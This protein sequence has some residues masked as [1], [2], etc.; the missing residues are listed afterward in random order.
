MNQLWI[1]IQKEFL[2]TIRNRWL[3]GFVIAYL[4]LSASI[5]FTAHWQSQA[6]DMAT[7]HRIDISLMNLSLFLV[8]L[9][10][11]IVSSQNIVTEAQDGFLE[12]LAVY[13]VKWRTIV[14]GKYFGIVGALSVGILIGFGIAGLALAFFTTSLA[15]LSFIWLLVINVIVGG[16]FVGIGLVISTHCRSRGG[17]LTTAI[18]IWLAAVLLY[19]LVIMQVIVSLQGDVSQFIFNVLVVANPVDLARLLIT[20]WLHIGVEF[21]TNSGMLGAVIAPPLSI[22]ITGAIVWMVVPVLLCKKTNFSA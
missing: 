11:L 17:A 3:A 22:M 13:P 1:T 15:L 7:L 18:L 6:L 19:D 10:A 20:H 5:G 9:I 8:P 2:Q 21:G 16:A 12:L 4:V 14:A